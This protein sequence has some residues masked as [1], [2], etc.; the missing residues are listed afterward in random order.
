MISGSTKKDREYAEKALVDVIEFIEVTYIRG[1]AEDY[2]KK[3]KDEQMAYAM[4]VDLRT[5]GQGLLKLT[6]N[7]EL[8]PL[9]EF[10]DTD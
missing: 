2:V 4:E 10:D 3:T 5:G 1:T 8:D 9:P 6:Q 7:K